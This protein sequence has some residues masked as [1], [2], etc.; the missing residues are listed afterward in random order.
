MGNR[1]IDFFDV[2]DPLDCKDLIDPI[3]CKESKL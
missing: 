3:D 2:L 1:Q